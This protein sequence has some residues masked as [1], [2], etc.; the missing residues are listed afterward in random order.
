MPK[1]KQPTLG[2]WKNKIVASDLQEE[3]DKCDFD[4]TKGNGLIGVLNQEYT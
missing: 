3:R 2:S 4:K 1:Q